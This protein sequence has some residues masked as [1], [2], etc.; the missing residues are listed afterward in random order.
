MEGGREP[1][2]AGGTGRSGHRDHPLIKKLSSS[3]GSRTS[4]PTFLELESIAR[5]ADAGHQVG[6]LGAC[7]NWILRSCVD[8]DVSHRASGTGGSVRVGGK[9]PFG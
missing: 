8:P 3:A 5:V 4:S 9:N 2:G 7:W 1:G 6:I